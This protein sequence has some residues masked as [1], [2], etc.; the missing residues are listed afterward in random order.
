VR[1]GSWIWAGALLA[2]AVTSQQFAL[3]VLAPLL[4]IAPPN[5]RFS[6]GGAAFGTWVLIIVPLL[7]ITS[8]RALRPAVLGSSGTPTI[9]GTLLWDVHARGILLIVLSRVV[10]IVVAMALARWALRRL[11]PSTLEPIPLT[12]LICT[13][14]GLRLLFEVSL[15]GYYLMALA[16]SLVLLN[17]VCGHIRGQL[18][19]WLALVTVVTNPVPWGFVSNSVPWGL[20]ERELLPFIA[21]GLGLLVIAFDALRGQLRWYLIGWLAIVTIAFGRLPWSHS[22]YRSAFPNWFWQIALLVPGLL[23]AVK[24]LITPVKIER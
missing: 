12:A 20:H 16:V 10:P 21:I 13:S 3:L 1:R 19:A 9:A 4:V 5:R 7:A 11:G 17:V 23:M 2:L 14:L 15:F 6:F 18:L 8:G 24:P 22:P